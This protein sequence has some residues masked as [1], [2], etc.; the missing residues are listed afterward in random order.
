MSVPVPLVIGLDVGGSSVKYVAAALGSAP[1][2]A[3][4]VLRRGTLATPGRRPVAGLVAAVAEAC[5]SDEVHALAV[6]IPGL[7]DSGTGRVIR[8]ANLPELDGVALQ[9]ELASALSLPVR[10]INDG[11]AAAIAEA[12]WGSG[13]GRADVFTLALGTGIAGAHVLDGQVRV[14]ANGSAGELGHV[15]VEPGGARCSCGQLGCL[16]T[17]VGAPALQAAWRDAGGSGS[18][19][20]LLRAFGDGDPRAVAVVE[21]AA[22]ALADAILTLLALVDPGCVVIGGGL[23]SAP[24]RLVLRA[25][26]LVAERASFHQVP[27]ILPAALGR[28]A[29]AVG[30]AA[31]ALECLGED[32]LGA[33]R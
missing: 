19:V 2:D 14:G 29:G 31:T 11:H 22:S 6:S 3:P 24:H 23:A 15:V 17:I 26:Q 28:W 25:A 32:A 10:V 9:E 27:P 20:E 16:E 33:T 1:G 30:S 12:R 21:R 8:V 18:P 13:Q 5:G 7:I 4:Q